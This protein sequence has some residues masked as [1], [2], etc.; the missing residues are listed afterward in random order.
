MKKR[1]WLWNHYA[2]EMYSNRYGRHFNLAKYLIKAGFDVTIFC[3]D[4]FHSSSDRIDLGNSFFIE[5]TVDSIKFIFIKTPDYSGNGI[6]RIL[7]MAAF[8]FRVQKAAKIIS[9]HGKPDLIL[10]SSVHPLTCV[11]GIKT[12]KKFKIPCIVEI[13]DRWPTTI[14]NESSNPVKKLIMKLLYRGEKWIYEEADKIIF[15]VEGGAQYIVDKKWDLE[16]GGPIDVKNIY[17]VSN[18]VDLEV[19]DYQ[20]EHER[21]EDPGLDDP[22]TFNIGYIGAIRA[23]NNI[24]YLLDAAKYLKNPMVRVFIWGRGNEEKVNN[25]KKR[26]AEEKID[27]VKYKG[28]LERQYVPYVTKRLNLGVIAGQQSKQKH[29]RYGTSQNKSFEYLAAGIP[30]LYNMKDG[31]DKYKK[32]ECGISELLTSEG[33]AEKIDMYSTMK[34]E[35]YDRQCSNARKLAEEYD[36]KRLTEKLSQV[37]ETAINE[38]PKGEAE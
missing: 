28:Y 4:R 31:Y 21:L 18:G 27:N 5:E 13:R 19:F 9:K 2:T 17:Y 24:D 12:C 36:Y 32:Y 37:I 20:A 35:E 6:K 1:I 15:T 25:I 23:L 29:R 11:A 8:Y 10:A 16:N 33:F 22:E 7:N 38:Q 30:V 26:I 34:S 14:D 3:A